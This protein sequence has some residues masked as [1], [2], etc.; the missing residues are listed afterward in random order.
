MTLIKTYNN[1]RRDRTKFGVVPQ[2]SSVSESNWYFCY[3]W[4]IHIFATVSNWSFPSTVAN[5]SV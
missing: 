1:T 4:H 3:T 2:I 5:K